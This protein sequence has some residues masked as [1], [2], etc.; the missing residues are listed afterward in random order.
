M[1]RHLLIA[2]WA[3]FVADFAAAEVLRV[4]SISS[5][6]GKEVS[7]FNPFAQYLAA[8]LK[9]LGITEGKVVVADGIE[10]M[11]S[12][13]REKQVDVLIDSAYPVVAA[14]QQAGL[15]VILRRWKRGEAEYR[16]IFVARADGPVRNLADLRG[17][18]VAFEDPHSTT[19]YLLPPA[20]LREAGHK[21]RELAS[22]STTPTADEIGT[23]FSGSKEG[24]LL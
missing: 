15:D 11:A 8:Q 13:L 4:G 10:A 5:K 2:L 20:V 9:D 24:T 3:V 1:L 12:K 16:S 22:T 6:P 23:V 21:Q 19:G 14:G 7:L 17:K 18:V